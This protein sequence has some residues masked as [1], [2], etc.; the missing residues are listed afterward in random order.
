[1]QNVLETFTWKTKE[2]DGNTRK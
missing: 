1:M 2:G